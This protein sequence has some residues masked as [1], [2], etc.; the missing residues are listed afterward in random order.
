MDKNTMNF[1]IN[2]DYSEIDGYAIDV[3][4]CRILECLGIEDVTKLTI[5]ELLQLWKQY[6]WQHD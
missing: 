1:D 4:E 5:G 2:L 3:N 6:G